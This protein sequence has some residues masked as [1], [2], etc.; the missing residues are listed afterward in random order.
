MWK[1]ILNNAIVPIL[2]VSAGT[3]SAIAITNLSRTQ[4]LPA[5]TQTKEEA[6][7]S[8]AI[9]PYD[10]I[11][12]DVGEKY[13]IDWRLLS[14]IART[15]SQFRFDAVSKVGAIGIMQIMPLVAHNMGYA[16]EAL[17][18]IQT[19][20]EVA[21]RLLLENNKMLR[22][23][24]DFDQKER[25]KFILACYNAGYP[26]I[27][28]ARRLAQYHDD[29]DENWSIVSTYLSLLSEPEFATHE[30][31]RSGAFYG[32]DE[33]ITYVNKVVHIYNIYCNR[34]VL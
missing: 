7:P 26:R 15:E 5:S 20:V 8:Y 4:T 22:L 10:K 25:L 9:S 34:I 21:A 23:H 12:Q 2:F 13:G 24:D 3:L 1:K 27:A 16:R 14:A 32:S 28:D 33:T 18:D 11:F 30:V 29:D 31:V 19:N 17:F 6:L